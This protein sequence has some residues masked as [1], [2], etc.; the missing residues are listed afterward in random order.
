MTIDMLYNSSWFRIGSLSVSII[1]LIVG[2]IIVYKAYKQ[3]KG[4]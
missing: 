2:I 4:D 1:C 3:L